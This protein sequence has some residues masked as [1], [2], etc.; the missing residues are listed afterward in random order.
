MRLLA[1][2]GRRQEALREYEKL[3]NALHD[4][5]DVDPAPATRRVYENILHQSSGVAERDGRGDRGWRFEQRVSFAQV[6]GARIAYATVGSGPP[7]VFA[8]GWL[9]HLEWMWQFAPFRRFTETLAEHHTV[10]RYD[11]LGTGLSERQRLDTS[12]EGDIRELEGVVETLGLQRFDLFGAC[13]TANLAAAYSQRHPERVARMVLYGAWANG[14]SL[15]S[16]AVQASLLGLI[17]AHWGLGSQTMADMF[18]AGEDTPTRNWFGVA[19]R[20]SA[21][22]EMAAALLA[23]LYA[24]DARSM[25]RDLH[26]PTLVVHRRDDRAVPFRHGS[27]VAALVPGASLVALDGTA[28][29][30]YC[31][32]SQPIL[33]AIH[34]FLRAA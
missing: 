20:L 17:R 23:A 27:E 22:S 28:H 16:G 24:G 5:L 2:T 4:D 1:A 11:R 26:V 31:G 32:D 14:T 13:N 3:R 33:D 8:P 10:I 15:A 34:D 7:L 18:V 30:P 21:S 9:S 12:L 25:L 6:N 29:L 19:Q